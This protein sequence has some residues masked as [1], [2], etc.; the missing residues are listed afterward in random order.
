MNIPPEAEGGGMLQS[1]ISQAFDLIERIFVDA[2]YKL[3]CSG[4]LH[5]FMVARLDELE[6]DSGAESVTPLH[7]SIMRYA[8]CDPADYVDRFQTMP[9]EV[10]PLDRGLV[11]QAIHVD[12]NRPRF[13]QRMHNAARGDMHID[14]NGNPQR[15]AFA[16]PPTENV[17]PDWPLLEVFWRSA[18]PWTHVEGMEPPPR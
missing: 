3:W 6:E 16:G 1:R 2:N 9:A 18:L 7:P 12:P 13:M 17:D 15:M 14:M 4:N 11:V 8:S 10:D 5:R